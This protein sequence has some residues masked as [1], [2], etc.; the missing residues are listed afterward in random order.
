MNNR[1]LCKFIHDHREK[2]ENFYTH[3]SLIQPLG[4]IDIP[5]KDEENF[6]EVYMNAINNEEKDDEK[7]EREE[8]E[9]IKPRKE[10]IVGLGERPNDYM[11]VLNDTDIKVYYDPSIHDKNK[12]L[13]SNTHIRQTVMIYQKYLKQSITNYKPNHGIC[14]VLEK[15]TPTIDTEKNIISHGFHLHFP[16]TF[17]HKVNQDIHLIPRIRKEIGD[18]ALFKDLGIVD[19]EATIDKSC[20]RQNWLLYGSRKDPSKQAYELTKIYNDQCEEISIENALEDFTLYN[21]FEDKIEMKPDQYRYYLPRILSTNSRRKEFVDVKSDL[22]IVTKKMMKKATESKKVYEDL[23]VPDALKKARELMKLISPDRAD[24]YEDWMN[25]GWLLYNIG[26]GTEEAFDLWCDFSKNTK[27]TNYFSETTCLYHWERM[28]KRN[29]TIGSLHFYAKSDSPDGYRALQKKDNER[30]F[31]DSLNGGHYDMAKLLHNTYR[32]NFVCGCNEKNVWFKF[33]NH[34]WHVSKQGIDLRKKISMDLVAHYKEK[35]KKICNEM[36]DEDDDADSQKKLKVINKIIANLKSTTFKNNVLKECV[37]LFYDSGFSSK[38]DNDPYLLGFNNGVLDLHSINGKII[39]FRPGRPTDFISKS[40]GYDFDESY[41]W[42]HVDV[43]ET[44]DHMSKIFPDP[45]L[46]QY[47]MEYCGSLLKGGNSSKTFLNMNGAGDNGKS[48]NMDLLKLVL[49]DYMKILPTSL[50]VGKRTQSSQ[51]TPELSNIPGV[52]LAIFQEPDVKDMYNIGVLK[53]LSGNDLM[54][55]RGLFK[56]GQEVRPLFKICLIC[57]TLP[58]LPSD[59]PATWN[60]IRV[61]PHE[62]S[63]PKDPSTVPDSIDEQFRVKRF[64]RDPFFSEKLP[65]MKTAFMWIMLESYKRVLREGRMLEPEKVR[66]ATA[67]YRRNNDVFLQ[68]IDE[69]IIE[70]F[71]NEKALISVTELYTAFKTWFG[72]S[73]PNMHG[74]IP[75]KEDL[76]NEMIK[77]WGSMT[78]AHKFKG[79][80][81]RTPEDDE[82]EGLALIIRESDLV[83]ENNKTSEPNKKRDVD[84][85]PNVEVE[86]EDE[87]NEDE[88]D[89]KNEDEIDEEKDENE[90]SKTEEK[91]ENV[92]EVDEWFDRVSEDEESDEEND[93]EEENDESEEEMEVDEDD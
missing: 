55:I 30:L 35:R 86:T 38:L 23:P 36:G 70:D 40:V 9:E 13:Y 14:F 51:A 75:S 81:L 85:N 62:A 58:N 61:L 19:S 22:N 33:D 34:R 67:T 78:P 20:T 2:G 41:T 89:E 32:D 5:R 28:E 10:C 74:R 92:D 31:N 29:I 42:D 68:F 57:N 71:E 4:R 8:K 45:E 64:P 15:K 88:I 11:P 1:E 3:V 25:I 46:K 56:D 93:D 76:K 7:E 53:E 16:F 26:D 84:Y 73:Y 49:G 47:Y 6:W 66:S 27:K 43:I 87:E 54:Y 63:F 80:R 37:E 60:R 18:K 65:R 59:D 12:K 77:K 79:F 50:I 83:K 24:S 91:V 21:A 69:R 48:I 17:M 82:K 90:E 72:D 52:R 44:M 39:G